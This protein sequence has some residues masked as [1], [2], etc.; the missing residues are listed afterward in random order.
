MSDRP[1]KMSVFMRVLTLAAA[2]A[3]GVS[4]PAHAAPPYENTTPGA[5][6]NA[7]N[8]CGGTEFIR[9]IS[10]PDSIVL[11]DIDVGLLLSHTWRED[12]RVSL[13]SP[14]GTT[15]VLVNDQGG[16]GNGDDNYNILIDD[17]LTT[18]AAD[19]GGAHALTPAY[20][21]PVASANPLSAFHGQNAQGTWT[22]SL[23]D[24]FAQDNGN[25]LSAELFLTGG[26]T[27]P[28]D[29]LSCPAA[30]LV[31]LDWNGNAWPSGT[32]SNQYTVS[33]TDFDFTVSGATGSLQND[34]G[35]GVSTPVTSTYMTGG[36]GAT[37]Q[38]VL[39]YANY[40]NNSSTV[41]V[42]LDVGD[43]SGGTNNGVAELQF[44]V[45][46]VDFGNNQFQDQLTVT[47]TN[48]VSTVTPVL[49]QG[50]ANTVSGNVVTG[51][52]PAGNAVADGNVTVTFSERVTQVSF[53][54]G[55]GANVPANPGNQAIALHDILICPFNP[56]ILAG[57]KTTRT[58][59]GGYALPGN[60]MYYTISVNNI[61]T[62]A[63]DDDSVFLVDSLPTEVE[64]YRGP[65]ASVPVTFSETGTGLDPFDYAADVGFSNAAAKPTSF[66]Q[67]NYTPAAGY[68][69]AVRYICFNPKGAMAAGDPN[70][71]FTYEFRVRIK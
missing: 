63:T 42:T 31:R 53:I 12:V 59:T 50:S 48:G 29:Q 16:G 28:P 54:Y 13:T 9:T 8:P 65:L 38:S 1:S 32:L 10:V 2:L 70:P 30:D 55:N 41:T 62:G 57:S 36:T 66:A 52:S 64:F 58:V 18:P 69:P 45:F 23:C 34:P 33:G 6:G 24:V 67:C 15:V 46:D 43:L 51:Q 68:D 37:Q 27:T 17:D 3:V 40:P 60:D 47:G 14:L 35:Q 20:A 19:S 44:T 7:A 5:F 56:A 49:T 11:S 61:G 26:G 71:Q 4:G 21:N 22:L 39:L 25:F